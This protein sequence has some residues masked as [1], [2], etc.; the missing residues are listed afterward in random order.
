MPSDASWSRFGVSAPQPL[1]PASPH[2]YNEC[3]KRNKK[4]L[5]MREEEEEEGKED[6][7][8]KWQPQATHP[9]IY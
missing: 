2:A 6:D 8:E 3:K 5:I 4:K 7:V 9:I 1:N